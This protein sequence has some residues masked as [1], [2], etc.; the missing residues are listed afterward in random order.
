M[1]LKAV[2]PSPEALARETLIV[3]G[4]AVLAAFILHQF[5]ALKDYIKDAWAK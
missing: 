5:P 1:N 3:L 2:I 4:G